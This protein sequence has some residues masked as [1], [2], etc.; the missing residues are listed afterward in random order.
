MG[1]PTTY[2]VSKL[3]SNSL[4]KDFHLKPNGFYDINEKNMKREQNTLIAIG[5]FFIFKGRPYYFT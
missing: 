4:L 3:D 5:D 2:Y 1:T